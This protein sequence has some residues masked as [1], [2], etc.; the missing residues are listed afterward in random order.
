MILSRRGVLAGAS[1]ALAPS[2]AWARGYSQ[3]E[4]THGVASGDPTANAVVIWTRFAPSAGGDGRIGWEIAEDDRFA[5]IERRG[6]A[7]ASAANDF[8]VKIDVGGLKPGRRYAYRFLGGGG[9]SPTGLTRTAPEGATDA[10]RF[11]FFSCAN[12][13]FGYFHAYGDAAARED[14]DLCLHVGDYFYEAGRGDYPSA[15]DAIPG[16]VIEPATEIIKLGDYDQRYAS[17][18]RDA[19]LLELRRT[20]PLCVVW[21]DH[22]L[23]NDAWRAGAQNHQPDKE[24]RWSD[25]VAAA[26]KAYFQWMPIRRPAA[27]GVRIYRSLDWGDLARIVMLDTRLIGRDQ[28]IGRDALF[29]ALAAG[30]PDADAALQKA[31]DALYAPARTL[32]G[33]TQEA[34]LA[35][36]LR[37]SK[38]RG[39]AWQVL[40]Q[41]IVMGR[42]LTPLGAARWLPGGA[43]A[44]AKAY[45]AGRERLTSQ[46]LGWNFDAWD[47]YPMARERLLHVCAA[48]AANTLVLSGDSHNCWVNNLEASGGRRLAAIE[49]AGGSV[50]SPGLE[51]S[52]PLAGPGEREAAIR[53]A[54]PNLAWCD[55]TYRGYGAVHL[56]R[57][58]CV[59]EWRAFESVRSTQ[60]PA[61]MVKRLAAEASAAG[62]PGKWAA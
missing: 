15:A 23:A 27:S 60:R 12:M 35:E 19:D 59:A 17:Y 25:R 4:F 31:R 24:G 49:F 47:G 7:R 28:Q 33:A 45:L 29:N 10:L 9:P 48:Q 37:A 16:R 3:G 18:H 26:S 11:A 1:L 20:K 52:F 54:N 14:I 38:G 5:Q 44:G 22:E 43:P 50:T 30:G 8:C 56:T 13:P 32:M 55:A 62:G 6:E 58:S 42:Q 57:T 53:A 39:Q 34:W 21:D 40:A 41:Q 46:G 51:R 2:A 61:P 36:T